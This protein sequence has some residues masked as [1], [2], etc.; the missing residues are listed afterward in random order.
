MDL[1]RT[2]RIAI[3]P[4]VL[5]LPHLAL[6]DGAPTCE[7]VVLK[8]R[9]VVGEPIIVDLVV[10]NESEDPIQSRVSDNKRF[11][12]LELIAR[13]RQGSEVI[14]SCGS[15]L[16][17]VHD[18]LYKARNPST[19]EWMIQLEPGRELR[20][21]RLFV[22]RVERSEPRHEGHDDRCPLGP[23][24]YTIT[25]HIPW[26][27]G[28]LSTPP[29]EIEVVAPE[30]VEDR[31]AAALVDGTFASFMTYEHTIVGM[32]GM[33]PTGSVKR[34]L[35]DCPTSVHARVARSRLLVLQA[36]KV[37]QDRTGAPGAERRERKARMLDLVQR[38]EAHLAEDPDDPLE[39]DLLKAR[40]GLLR[41]F[42]V[43]D[44]LLNAIDDLIERYPDAA[45]AEDAK[46]MR[47][48]FLQYRAKLAR[49]K[50]AAAGG[51]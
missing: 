6:A 12:R 41:L 51:P 14:S 29:V 50:D 28:R 7:A 27:D 30:E 48:E 47:D 40:V 8:N 15:R 17:C 45:Y 4:A 38:I 35:D 22:F 2:Q 36:R 11:S 1:A 3:L 49:D 9:V 18:P 10:R 16:Y 13:V 31:A 21:R 32:S 33:S 34:I 37:L 42:E 39:F 23:G 25:G 20:A 44:P 26:I 19:G 43:V 5:F 46:K 24:T